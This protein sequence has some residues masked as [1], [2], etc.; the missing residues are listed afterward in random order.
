M[1]EAWLGHYFH[2]DLQIVKK[3]LSGFNIYLFYFICFFFFFRAA[4]EAYGCSQ[5]RG[6]IRD[7]TPGH[8]PM[9][10]PQQQLGIQAVSTT[11]TTAH[12]N[13]RSLTH[14]A[15]PGIEPATTWF[16]VGF[17]NH[18]AWTGTPPSVFS[19]VR[20]RETFLV[21]L[22]QSRYFPLRASNQHE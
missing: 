1:S 2:K 4:P 20:W 10:E 7:V 5:A 15:R 3:L 9:P 6:W 12:G 13:A 21:Y 16:L 18:G 17:V 19:T 14:W 11:Y 8:W 22:S